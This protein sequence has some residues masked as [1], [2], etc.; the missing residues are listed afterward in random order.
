[1]A[2]TKLHNP[3]WIRGF[4]TKFI[5][6]VISH[7]LHFHRSRVRIARFLLHLILSHPSLFEP[8]GQPCSHAEAIKLKKKLSETVSG[9]LKGKKTSQILSPS[10][11]SSSCLNVY[12]PLRQ[13]RGEWRQHKKI[14]PFNQTSKKQEKNFFSPFC[15]D[16]TSQENFFSPEK[17]TMYGI[18]TSH[19]LCTMMIQRVQTMPCHTQVRSQ[20]L[21]KKV[22][23]LQCPSLFLFLTVFLLRLPYHLSKSAVGQHDEGKVSK[24]INGGQKKPEKNWLDWIYRD[25][26]CCNDWASELRCVLR[27]NNAISA[28]TSA[29]FP[30]YVMLPFL[31]ATL[32]RMGADE[33]KKI[34]GKSFSLLFPFYSIFF[35]LNFEWI[36]GSWVNYK[37]LFFPLLLVLYH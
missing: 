13:I 9:K 14:L 20:S 19:E 29:I 7:F 12:T 3:E 33:Q 28:A 27:A 26:G 32:R 2:G 10:S 18:S 15:Y 22:F 35:L 34:G 6:L 21:Q 25:D 8:N 11:Q 36:R 37:S 1:M 23:F 30:L 16:E 4:H 31:C 5:I 17:N 24:G